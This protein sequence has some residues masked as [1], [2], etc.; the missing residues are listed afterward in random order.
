MCLL[1]ILPQPAKKVALLSC[2]AA[3]SGVGCAVGVIMTSH[4]LESSA[5]DSCDLN[6]HFRNWVGAMLASDVQADYHKCNILNVS[7]PLW[8][9]LC[10]TLCIAGLN[11]LC[12]PTVTSPLTPIQPLTPPTAPFTPGNTVHGSDVQVLFVLLQPHPDSDMRRRPPVAAS[13]QILIE[14]HPMVQQYLVSHLSPPLPP[15]HARQRHLPPIACSQE[16]FDLFIA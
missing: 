14:G 6:V 9:T 10:C 15:L 12:T 16:N 5:A 3:N 2:L 8:W 7:S 11:R 13:V 4:K 1:F